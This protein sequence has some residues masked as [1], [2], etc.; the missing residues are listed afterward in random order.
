MR[1]KEFTWSRRTSFEPVSAAILCPSSMN[2]RFLSR[3]IKSFALFSLASLSAFAFEGKV[4]MTMTTKKS[5]KPMP[6]SYFI[7]GDHLRVEVAVPDRKH[8]TEGMTMAMI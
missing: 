2:S 6:I 7:K 4:D 1:K 8:G 3:A 5:E